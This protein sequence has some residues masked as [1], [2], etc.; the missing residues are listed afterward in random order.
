MMTLGE[1]RKATEH[2]SD[3]C[4]LE[5]ADSDSNMSYTFDIDSVYV[6]T[7]GATDENPDT[8]TAIVIA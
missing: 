1:F 3:D 8:K 4:E 2:L 7:T 6:R 5:R